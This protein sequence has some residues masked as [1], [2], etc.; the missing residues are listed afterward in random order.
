MGKERELFKQDRRVATHS[1]MPP[2]RAAAYKKLT[3]Q[4]ELWSSG[5]GYRH[6][7]WSWGKEQGNNLLNYPPMPPSSARTSVRHGL[8][9]IRET[10]AYGCRPSRSDS[11]TET[12]QWNCREGK[13]GPGGANGKMDTQRSHSTMGS[14]RKAKLRQWWL[15]WIREKNSKNITVWAM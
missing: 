2:V 4:R 8:V 1:R 14:I 7:K 5:E 12:V 10:G 6:L 11:W 15:K 9:E 13:R 3:T